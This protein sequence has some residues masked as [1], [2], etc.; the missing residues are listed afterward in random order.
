MKSLFHHSAKPSHYNKEAK[1]YDKFNEINLTLINHTIEKILKK[2]KVKSV[3]DLTCGTGSQVF[4]LAK[5]GYEVVGS[6]INLKML[7]I[8]KNKAKKKNYV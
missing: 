2:Y 4:W 8:A 6:D 7:K 3:F 5:R 1:H